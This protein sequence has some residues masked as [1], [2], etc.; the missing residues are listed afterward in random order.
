M[1]DLG[2]LKLKLPEQRLDVVN[3]LVAGKNEE[4][5]HRNP[6][7]VLPY[8]SVGTASRKDIMARFPQSRSII[9]IPRPKSVQ[10]DDSSRS[11]RTPSI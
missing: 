1:R 8:A 3:C 9:G 10:V 4:V 6:K 7:R 2:N 5:Q 11:L